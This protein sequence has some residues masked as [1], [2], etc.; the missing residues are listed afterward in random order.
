VKIEPRPESERVNIESLQALNGSSDSESERVY[1]D[2]YRSLVVETE[3]PRRGC[4][5]SRE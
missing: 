4:V 3:D 5:P 1:I 2:G